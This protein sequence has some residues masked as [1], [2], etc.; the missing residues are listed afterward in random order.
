MMMTVVINDIILGLYVFRI[1]AS[2]SAA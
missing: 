2:I 1:A